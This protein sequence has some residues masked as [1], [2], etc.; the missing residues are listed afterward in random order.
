[1]YINFTLLRYHV[2]GNNVKVCKWFVHERSDVVC[3]LQDLGIYIWVDEIKQ[4]VK[5]L[6]NVA[7]FW[8]VSDDQRM[9]CQELLL[10]FLKSLFKLILNLLLLI[11]KFLLEVKEALV[12]IL[13]LLEFESFK[14]FLYLFQQ[15]RVFI[16]QSLSIKNHLLEI[17]YILFETWCHFF[18]LYK[19]MTVVLVKYTSDTNGHRAKFTKILDRLIIMP[20]TVDIIVRI[21][22]LSTSSPIKITV[23]NEG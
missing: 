21:H 8:K 17:K 7:N 19:F 12:D 15:L 13:H 22:G 9:L 4:L 6:L 14:F 20:R 3:S 18:N 16:V 23:C 11:F 1:M 2:L 5:H 10:L